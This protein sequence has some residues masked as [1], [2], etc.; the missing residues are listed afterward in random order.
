MKLGFL[1]SGQICRN[2]L[3]LH[4]LDSRSDPI[5]NSSARQQE[6]GRGTFRN[7][8]AYLLDEVLI[9]PIVSKVSGECTHG[10]SHCQSKEWDKEQQAEQH[11]PERTTQCARSG[12][13][14]ELPGLGFLG[15]DR[16]GDDGG[17]LHGDQLLQLQ[18]LQPIQ[19]HISPIRGWKLQYS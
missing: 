19:H 11:P 3:E 13:A 1:L 14:V 18:L 10:S 6:Q 8:V 7:F 9:N 15:P 12:S 2:D 5:D 17:I 16:P 4:V